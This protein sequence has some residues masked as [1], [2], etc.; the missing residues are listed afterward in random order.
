[1]RLD[2]FLTRRGTHSCKQVATLLASGRICVDGHIESHGPRKINRF[3][4]ITLDGEILQNREAIYLMLHKPAGHLS[5][6]SDPEHPTVIELIQHPLRHELH[7]AGRLDRASTGLLLLT[8]DGKWSRHVTEPDEEIS[9]IYRVTTRDPITPDT[10]AIFTAGIYFAFED[11]TTR[12]AQLQ[13]LAPREALLSIHEGRYHQ[14]K[15]MFH[16]VGNQVLSLHREKIGH[17]PLDPALAPG[18]SRPLTPAEIALFLPTKKELIRQRP[19]HA[20]NGSESTF[21]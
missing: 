21:P 13:I 19:P 5:A 4:E 6:T 14:V 17:L 18:D 9:K 2:R 12:P 15:R 8:N 3:S 1:M 16:A 10:A 11:L 20:P 7:L